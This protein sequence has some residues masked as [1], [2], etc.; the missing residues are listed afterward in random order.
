[1]SV[2]EEYGLALLLDAVKKVLENGRIDELL[3]QG[4]RFQRM[5]SQTLLDRNA[6][7][8]SAILANYLEIVN[9]MKTL[10]SD[11]IVYGA[12]I[13][14][15]EAEIYSR[16]VVG[17]I[18]YNSVCMPVIVKRHL[19]LRGGIARPGAVVCIEPERAVK[20]VAAGIAE[21]IGTGLELRETNHNS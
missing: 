13:G 6:L 1:M 2:S 3:S 12:G 21:P 7:R 10:I 20:L 14:V 19:G 17:E 9:E 4:A 11:T 8:R 15:A 18:V 16:L 5:L